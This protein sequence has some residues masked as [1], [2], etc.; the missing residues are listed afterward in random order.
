MA[1]TDLNRRL[2]TLD[3]SFL[4]VERPNQ[5]M[6]VGSVNV[7]EGHVSR[8]VL[9][10][11]LQRRLHLLP[12]YRQRVV[13][14]PFGVAHP[15]WE[16]DPSL[17]VR[18]HVEEVMLPAPGDDRVLSEVGGRLFG[19]VL[20]RQRPLW[21]L[22]LL[23]GHESGNTVMVAMIHHAM[24]DGVSG[25]ELQMVLHDLTASAEHPAPPATP[26]DPRPLP[27]P[28]TLL[29]DAVR[30]LLTEAAQTW[31]EE[32]FRMFRPGELT[33]RAEQMTKAM[34]TSMPYVMQP[35][36]RTPFNGPVSGERQFAWVECSFPEI[37]AIRGVLGGTVNDVVLTVL[38]GGLS[39]Y[40]RHHDYPTDGVELRAM[41]PVSMRR[42]EQ[43]EALGNLV[44]MMFAPLYVGIAD[45][46]ERLKAERSAMER[47][48]E[49]GQAAS[50]Y[51]MTDLAR[52][53]PA[54]WQAMAARMDLPN[55][56]LNTVST[57]VPGPQ[58]PLYLAGHKLLHWYPLGPLASG[59]GLF[60]A[61]LSYN[62]KLT[63]GT[64]V[65]PR[66]VPDVWLLAGCIRESY[67]ELKDAAQ[68]VYAASTPVPAADVASPVAGSGGGANGPSKARERAVAAG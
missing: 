12:R 55:T 29:Q 26:W 16:D 37:R 52:R 5:P 32:S 63:F 56:M 8:D 33:D 18:N 3:A 30:D 31:T 41:C 23:Q 45:P 60:V 44:S 67:D 21:R 53:I 20:D 68:R 2:T 48:K 61:M 17:D 22:V 35:A 28:L 65:D 50:L 10:E 9:I 51:A 59:I 57:N 34:T 27:D 62:Q 47:L 36:P 66:Q 43:Q 4:Y 58:I 46:V 64:T 13:F 49:E 39:R 11:V 38:A 54:G 7:Y 6:H 40:L 15:T 42:P 19:H 14:P 25:V 1:R 24:V